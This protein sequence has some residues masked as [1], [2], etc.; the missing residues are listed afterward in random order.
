M[1]ITHT[2]IRGRIMDYP[3]H[4]RREVLEEEHTPKGCYRLEKIYTS[5]KGK[6]YGPYGPYWYLYYYKDGK[7]Y[8][9][10]IGKTLLFRIHNKKELDAV[11]E[12]RDKEDGAR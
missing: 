8:S 12:I 4:D 11:V 9:K 7:L 2:I 3:N 10:Y 5:K 1:L 6:L